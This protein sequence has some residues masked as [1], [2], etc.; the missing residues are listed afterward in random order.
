MTTLLATHSDL[1]TLNVHFFTVCVSAGA[2]LSCMQ[3]PAGTKGQ[4]ERGLGR[5]YLMCILGTK[6]SFSARADGPEAL[7]LH[8]RLLPLGFLF[9]SLLIFCLDSMFLFFL[10]WF[11]KYLSYTDP[12]NS[13]INYGM[14]TDFWVISLPCLLHPLNTMT[15]NRGSRN[16][17]LT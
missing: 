4:K 5:S 1:Q 6:P 10:F 2:M 15:E 7:S 13:A 3:V 14:C 17:D 11:F 9:S 16:R 12:L 8:S